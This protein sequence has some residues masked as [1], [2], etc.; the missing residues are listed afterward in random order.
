[1]ALKRLDDILTPLGITKG[2]YRQMAHG[3]MK[4]PT[5]KNFQKN[6]R[7]RGAEYLYDEE[8]VV[9]AIRLY[10]SRRTRTI[11]SGP[12]RPAT[13]AEMILNLFRV[14]RMKRSE[15]RDTLGV[16]KGSKLQEFERTFNDLANKDV[17]H[18][19]NKFSEPG[20]YAL[21]DAE[22]AADGAAP[23]EGDLSEGTGEGLPVSKPK[24][25]PPM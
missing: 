5:W 10:R 17:L 2:N 4:L 20:V 8:E 1:M 16:T 15:A 24:L 3:G 22:V 25:Q 21:K 14:R 6:T 11:E 9:E 7:G 18:Q 12:E 23:V 13:M 19:P